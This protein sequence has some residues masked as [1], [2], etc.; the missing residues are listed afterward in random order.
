[1]WA[2]VCTVKKHFWGNHPGKT[3]QNRW[4]TPR[5]NTDP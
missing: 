2:G 5:I 4:E 3:T 1:L